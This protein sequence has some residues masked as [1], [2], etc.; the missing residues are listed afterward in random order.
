MLFTSRLQGTPPLN[1]TAPN[2]AHSIHISKASQPTWLCVSIMGR[3]CE[4]Y[5]M[6]TVGQ[7]VMKHTIAAMKMDPQY[8]S[9]RGSKYYLLYFRQKI[10]GANE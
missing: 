7:R 5:I 8:C 4:Y 10:K 9:P 2:C 6:F 3:L 1:E